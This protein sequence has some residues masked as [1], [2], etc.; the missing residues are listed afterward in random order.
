MDVGGVVVDVAF[1]LVLGKVSVVWKPADA[2]P[3]DEFFL[4]LD[5]DVL[6]EVLDIFQVLEP[7]S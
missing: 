4:S 2:I 7:Y 1:A 3:V 5:D 6:E